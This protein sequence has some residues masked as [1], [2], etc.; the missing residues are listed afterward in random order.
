MNS[1]KNFGHCIKLLSFSP[2]FKINITE[3]VYVC[4]RPLCLPFIQNSSIIRGL[5]HQAYH[6]LFTE[7]QSI[8]GTIKQ[9]KKNLKTFAR[10]S[11]MEI[12][13]VYRIGNYIRKYSF[14]I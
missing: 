7:M 13:D 10:L 12:I 5:Y 9:P 14:Q 2:L 11:D 3:Y 4:N 6:I 1:R 8:A